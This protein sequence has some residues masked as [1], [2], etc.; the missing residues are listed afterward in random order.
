ML[1]KL[2]NSEVDVHI[3]VSKSVGMFPLRRC[4]TM[5]CGSMQC[6]YASNDGVYCSMLI[7]WNEQRA[8]RCVDYNKDM[9]TRIVH[10]E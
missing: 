9:D 8:I 6:N 1:L 10:E 5:V 7:L 4:L 2:E 3:D